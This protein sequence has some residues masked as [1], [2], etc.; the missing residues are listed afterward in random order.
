MKIKGV[1]YESRGVDH[2]DNRR[3]LLTMFNGDLEDFVARQ[4]KILVLKEDAVIGGHYHDYGELFYLFD[5]AGSFKLKDIDRNVVEQYNLGKGDRL[6]IPKGV[7]H[8]GSFKRGSV[9][10]GC[11]EIPY[12]SPENN[13]HRYDF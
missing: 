3:V 1:E 8:K 12:L 10:I 5:G 13:D 7:A 4:V 2:E 11:T 9:L 6:F